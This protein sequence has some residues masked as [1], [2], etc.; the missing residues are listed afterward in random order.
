MGVG[1]GAG[2]G[3]GTGV[4]VGVGVGTGTGVGVGT[5]VGGVG[6]GSTCNVNPGEGFCTVNVKVPDVA[7]VTV[8]VNFE[9]VIAD[10]TPVGT[11]LTSGTT[12]SLPFPGTAK[13]DPVTT[14]TC[15]V[16]LAIG[17]GLYP[18]IEGAE[19]ACAETA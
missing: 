1:A 8:H 19:L 14:S 2:V 13:F 5:G 4:G 3:G 7:N 10:A 17:A 12:P 15:A 9:D 11:P 16:G 6:R 18:V